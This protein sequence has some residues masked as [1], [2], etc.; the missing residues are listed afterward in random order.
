MSSTTFKVRYVWWHRIRAFS[1]TFWLLLIAVCL[2]FLNDL[3]K[4]SSRYA[5]LNA[6]QAIGLK[7]GNY[8]F[9]FLLVSFTISLCLVILDCIRKS[10]YY[11][12]VQSDGI[13]INYGYIYKDSLRF[14]QSDKIYEAVY[15]RSAIGKLLNFGY[16][17]IKENDGVSSRFKGGPFPN[18]PAITQ[19][20]NDIAIEKNVGKQVAQTTILHETKQ[21]NKADELEK[22]VEL[23]SQGKISAEEYNELKSKLFG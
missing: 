14:I 22:L 1:I 12:E 16:V 4:D 20:I 23:K 6:H 7:V 10:R 21:I 19:A 15:Y 18:V 13:S 2:F 3:A 5:K 11:W 17:E 9:V 8:F